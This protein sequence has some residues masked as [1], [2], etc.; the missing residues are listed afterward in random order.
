MQAWHRPRVKTNENFPDITPAKVSTIVY[1]F[2]AMTEQ[3]SVTISTEAQGHRRRWERATTER[4]NRVLELSQSERVGGVAHD[5][6]HKTGRGRD[7]A[8]MRLRAVFD[9]FG[10]IEAE[11]ATGSQPRLV[12]SLVAGPREDLFTAQ[13]GVDALDPEQRSGVSVHYLAFGRLGTRVLLR[14]VWGCS[15]SNLAIDTWFERSGDPG[16][17]DA[18]LIASHRHLLGAPDRNATALL[19]TDVLLPTGGGGFFWGTPIVTVS[20]D[21]S[22]A[23]FHIRC[24][25]YLPNEMAPDDWITHSEELLKLRPGDR[26]MANTVLHPIHLGTQ[27]QPAT[28]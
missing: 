24:R 20:R 3:I 8:R 10:T 9:E 19:A 14:G 18:A 17:L 5:F 2:R 1:T 11:A 27:Q 28:L 13:P 25:A 6:A 26:A 4:F 23:M 12:Y 7:K 16:G 15:L 22:N 21:T